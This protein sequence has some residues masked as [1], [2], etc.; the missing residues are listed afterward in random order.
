M[1]LIEENIC[2][3]DIQAALYF[4]Y[5]FLTS[6]FF[7]MHQKVFDIR[8]NG[9]TEKEPC[10][11]KRQPLFNDMRIPLQQ[12]NEFINFILFPVC[13]VVAEA[14]KVVCSICKMLFQGAYL[15][16]KIPYFTFQCA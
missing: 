10:F 5:V 13:R 3:Q 4:R 12:G 7:N 16:D 15:P 6:Q 11:F 9:L 1:S 8:N 14:G 2:S